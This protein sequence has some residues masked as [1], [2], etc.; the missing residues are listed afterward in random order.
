[1]EKHDLE[2]IEKYVGQDALLRELYK[3]HLDLEKKLESFNER[4]YLTPKD[5]L[6]RARLKK[7]KL[8]GRDKIE[9]ILNKYR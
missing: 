4:S 6:E 1:M 3:E 2:L 5:E 9:S 8:K 7:I